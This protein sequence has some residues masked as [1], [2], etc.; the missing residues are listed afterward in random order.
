MENS[1]WKQMLTIE[2][3]SAVKHSL[4]AVYA[5]KYQAEDRGNSHSWDNVIKILSELLAKNG[6]LLSRFL[7]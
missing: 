6:V 3:I 5:L 2:E 4:N 7:F 1:D